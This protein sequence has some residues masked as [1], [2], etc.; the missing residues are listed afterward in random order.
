MTKGH[1]YELVCIYCKETFYTHEP[2]K[3]GEHVIVMPDGLLHY[4]CFDRYLGNRE[5][6]AEAIIENGKVKYI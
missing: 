2:I 6:S 4:D 3:E 5:Y 1:E